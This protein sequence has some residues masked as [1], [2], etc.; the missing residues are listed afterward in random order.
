MEPALAGQS[1]VSTLDLA[2]RVGVRGR[3]AGGEG[4]D[5]PPCHDAAGDVELSKPPREAR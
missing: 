2:Q 3:R 1:P 5:A 4:E